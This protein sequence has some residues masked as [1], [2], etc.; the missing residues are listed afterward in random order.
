MRTHARRRYQKNI[1]MDE[2]ALNSLVL[3]VKKEALGKGC[4]IT[5]STV[6]MSMF[7]LLTTN[8]K[9]ELIK[10]DPAR[11]ENG[12]II[13]YKGNGKMIAH[14]LMRKIKAKE[15]YLFVTK[16][17]AFFSYDRPISSDAIMGRV[18]KIKKRYLSICLEGISGR[19][20]NLIMFFISLSKASGLAVGGL[21]KIKRLLV[22]LQTNITHG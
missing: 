3:E 11:L 15:G 12:D 18:I 9:I 6:G 16:G 22:E 17:D 10:C 14:R 4:V 7:S 2:A 5:L 20:I 19:V 1:N 13:V 21:I 8:N